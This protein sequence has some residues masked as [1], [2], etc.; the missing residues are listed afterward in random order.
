MKKVIKYWAGWCGPCKIYAPIF[1]SVKNIYPDIEFIDVNVEEESEYRDKYKV[2]SIPY[3]VIEENGVMVKDKN[4][5]MS[6]DKLIE[7]INN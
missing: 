7:F 3:T 1:D 4:G 6:K 5:L 2:T